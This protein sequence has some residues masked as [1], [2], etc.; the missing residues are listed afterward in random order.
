MSLW[1]S[2][3]LFVKK[4]DSNEP[5]P[6]F[7][8]RLV[9]NVSIPMDFPLPNIDHELQHLAQFTL[10]ST[11]DLRSGFW[12]IPLDE[13]SRDITTFH[14]RFGSFRW[15]VMPF[16][17]RNGPAIFQKCM[18]QVLSGLLFETCLVYIDDVICYSDDVNSHINYLI[19]IL[20][21]LQQA[22]FFIHLKKCSF[23]FTTIK[24]LGHTIKH[25]TI[26]PSADRL[27]TIQSYIIDTAGSLRSFLGLA[28]Y[29]RRFIPSFAAIVRPLQLLSNDNS[30]NK[31]K[32]IVLT[33]AQRHVFQTVKELLCSNLQLTAPNW[34]DVF[35]L[36]TDA[37]SF[38]IG[39][40]LSQSNGP[41]TFISRGLTNIETRYSIIERETLSIKYSVLTLAYFLRNKP[42]QIKTDHQPLVYIFAGSTKEYSPRIARYVLALSP[43]TFTVSYLKGRY[44]SVADFLSRNPILKTTL[45][46]LSETVVTNAIVHNNH[47]I[48]NT[49]NTNMNINAQ[50]VSMS[51]PKPLYWPDPELY[52]LLQRQ[53]AHR[54]L[55]QITDLLRG[56]Y[57]SP[58]TPPLF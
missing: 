4:K 12:S 35:V 28:S 17:H 42:F 20:R 5:R 45:D 52:D 55:P 7:D 27:N 47:N 57:V 36:N 6:A 1:N 53:Q 14:T 29:Y 33:E 32:P 46:S 11:L 23:L 9:N 49:N 8:L 37:S 13:A 50:H 48:T 58:S 30:A 3:I 2:A 54:L 18:N 16:G 25:N 43:F 41:I 15:C 10:F 24:F 19:Q 44:N 22:D 51:N 56:N 39:A 34:E 40:C 38:A 26:A 21:R 31:R